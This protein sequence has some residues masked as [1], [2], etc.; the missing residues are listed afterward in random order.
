MLDS[1][2]LLLAH[3]T[4]LHTRTLDR[5]TQ[6]HSE[7]ARD[8]VIFVLLPNLQIFLVFFSFYSNQKTHYVTSSHNAVTNY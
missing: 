8:R 3:G 5:N 2:E 7:N 4:D 6:T 1:L